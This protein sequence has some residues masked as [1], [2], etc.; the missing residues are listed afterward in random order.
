MLVWSDVID[1]VEAGS[2]DELDF[3]RHLTFGFRGKPVVIT[4]SSGAGKSRIWSQLTNHADPRRMSASTDDG[5][6]VRPNKHALALRTIPGQRS[7]NRREAIAEI[8]GAKTI[9][10]GVIFVASFG[11]DH[12]WPKFA[13]SAA[14]ELKQ[15]DIASLRARNLRKE[16]DSFAEICNA[17]ADKQFAAPFE[18]LPKW[19][20]VTVNKLDLFWPDLS[21]AKEYYLPGC[22]SEFDDLAQKLMA[23]VGTNSLQYHVTPMASA[24][25]GYE[26]RTSRGVLTES[27]QLDSNSCNASTFCLIENLEELCDD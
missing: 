3:K 9:V 25:L 16:L 10:N 1:R 19:L 14:N 17:I 4:G 8:F 20:L 26:F 13:D 5:Y 18:W 22:G 23:R 11:Y 12:I 7:S 24:P 27:S 6:M 15:F 21:S 2:P